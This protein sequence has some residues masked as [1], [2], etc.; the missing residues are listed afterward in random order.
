MQVQEETHGRGPL[1]WPATIA[2]TV[3]EIY[4]ANSAHEVGS[5]IRLGFVVNDAVVVLERLRTAGFEV[6]K[7]L[8][9]GPWGVRAAVRDTDGRTVE[10]VQAATT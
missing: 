2:D 5:T 3:V 6:V 7:E 9:Q 8:S 10:I 1:H 4:P